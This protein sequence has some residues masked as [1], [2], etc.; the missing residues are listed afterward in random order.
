MWKKRALSWREAHVKVKRVKNW[1]VRATFGRSDAVFAWQAIGIVHLVKSEQKRGGFVALPTATITTLQLQL[2]LQ[3][4][5]HLQLQLHYATTSTITTSTTT[6]AAALRYLHYPTLHSTSLPYIT[7][8][9]ANYNYSHNHNHK[10]NYNYKCSCTTL[11]TFALRY[12][13]LHYPT[14]HYT[15]RHYYNYNYQ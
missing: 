13:P 7:L 14:W 6:N 5:L 12:T 10:Y 9:Y 15:T 2:P 8:H 3:Q 11:I 4:Q 1:E